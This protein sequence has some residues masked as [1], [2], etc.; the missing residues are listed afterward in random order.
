MKPPVNIE[1][2]R[3]RM[4]Q[5]LSAREQKQMKGATCS[6]KSLLECDYPCTFIVT[7]RVSSRI[8]SLQRLISFCCT[9]C[10][11]VSTTEQC[12]QCGSKLTPQ[13]MFSLALIDD[14]AQLKA[15][16]FGY[17]GVQ[18]F[19]SISAD[20]VL[21]DSEAN[22]QLRLLV[23]Q[24]T[25]NKPWKFCIKSYHPSGLKDTLRHKI[26]RTNIALQK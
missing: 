4:L 25:S 19:N 1:K 11:S 23:D 17:D 6:I 14:T 18:L 12:K 5:S 8:D 2:M 24:L 7:A 26:V 15:I 9:E 20:A 22:A 13:F 3:E 10:V 21:R 16:V